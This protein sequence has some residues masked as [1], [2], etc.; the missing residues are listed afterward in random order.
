MHDTLYRHRDIAADIRPRRTSPVTLG[1]RLALW[2]HRLSRRV[3]E[4]LADGRLAR[5]LIRTGANRDSQHEER[6]PLRGHSVP[7]GV[8][9][10]VARYRHQ[11]GIGSQVDSDA[12]LGGGGSA[13]AKEHAGNNNG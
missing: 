8:A 6:H 5:V 4:L 9:D 3:P 7:R 10:R 13:R 1:L 12:D 2:W 11:I